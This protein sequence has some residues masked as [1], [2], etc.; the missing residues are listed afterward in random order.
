MSAIQ[1]LISG[2][3]ISSVKEVIIMYESN[4]FNEFSNSLSDDS[5]NVH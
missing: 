1:F 5:D 2:E 4:N 3:R